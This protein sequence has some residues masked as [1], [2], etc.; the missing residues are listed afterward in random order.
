MEGNLC[1]K[2]ILD[3]IG[4]DPRLLVDTLLREQLASWGKMA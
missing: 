3:E 4:E 2:P 1:T